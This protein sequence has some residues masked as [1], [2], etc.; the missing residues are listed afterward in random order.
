MTA[1]PRLTQRHLPAELTA[2]LGATDEIVR[3]EAWV[4]FVERYS[5]LMLHTA[6]ARSRKYDGVME[7]YAYVLDQLRRDD[8]RRLRRFA[9]E[10][11]SSFS[12]WLVVV[13][14]RLCVDY[15]RQRYGRAGDEE[16]TRRQLEDLVSREEDL[17]TLPDLSRSTITREFTA[18][19]RHDVLERVL[20]RLDSTDRLL[21]RLRFEE[22]MTA[23]E[24]AQVPGFQSQAQ[25]YRRLEA[26]LGKLRAE[27][28]RAGIEPMGDGR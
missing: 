13:V 26:L 9:A 19:E 10:G 7:R 3:E 24:I 14:R 21:L 2:L 23:R 12:T 17:A 20:G 18:R 1:T 16:S 4:S 28:E 11:A 15:H 5:R 25:V 8:F 22:G 6:C 27:L